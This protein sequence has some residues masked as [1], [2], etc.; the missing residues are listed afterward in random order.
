MHKHPPSHM[1]K[2]KTWSR[3]SSSFVPWSGP[4]VYVS[5]LAWVLW[6][7]CRSTTL[8]VLTLFYHWLSGLSPIFTDICCSFLVPRLT[9][10]SYLFPNQMF[11]PWTFHIQNSNTFMTYLRII[12]HRSL[13]IL[14][15]STNLKISQS[16][17]ICKG[18]EIWS[19][20][21]FGAFP[22]LS[23]A[24]STCTLNFTAV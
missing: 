16:I 1:M 11:F 15:P 23:L 19:F 4:D 8:S 2:K 17:A 12:M 13:L 14:S 6:Q 20:Y 18:A 7:V 24:L 9:S 21:Y 5:M 10:I 3:S 22:H